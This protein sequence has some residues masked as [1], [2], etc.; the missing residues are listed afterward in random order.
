MDAARGIN[1]DPLDVV[2]D[3]HHNPVVIMSCLMVVA[4]GNVWN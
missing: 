3:N 1:I 2:V 4:H